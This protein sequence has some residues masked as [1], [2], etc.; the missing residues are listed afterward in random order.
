MKGTTNS[1]T[2]VLVY[3]R[4]TTPDDLS[5]QVRALG[6]YAGRLGWTVTQIVAEVRR[7]GPSARALTA[8]R[9]ATRVVIADPDRLGGDRGTALDVY[10]GLLAAGVGVAV[11]PRVDVIPTT[12]RETF[13]EAIA[14]SI[15]DMHRQQHGER[16]RRGLA[17]RREAQA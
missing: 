14:R 11:A 1:T 16:V 13:V 5:Q 10:A 7:A 8:L 3:A 2:T 9:S 6:D 17:R 15:D 4:S 12:D